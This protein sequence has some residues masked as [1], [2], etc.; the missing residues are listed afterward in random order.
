MLAVVALGFFSMCITAQAQMFSTPTNVSNN[1][2]FST[3]P[4]VA[5]DA[6]GNIYVV[7]EDDTNTNANILLGW[8]T[9]GGMKFFTKPLSNTKGFSSSPRICVDG[10]GAINVVWVDDTPG[11]PVVNFSR[12]TNG[13]TDFS[14]QQLSDKA[15][16]SA[17]PQIGVDGAGN[18]SVVWE[19]DSAPVG[20]LFR[21]STDGVTF[22]PAVNLA[23]NPVNPNLTGSLA[24]QMAVGVDGSINV[25]WEDDF[26]GQSDISFARSTDN[27]AT[28]S[29]TK[30]L[31]NNF[32]ASVGA[33]IAVDASGN[34]DVVWKDNTSGNNQILF[35]RSTDQGAHFL[36]A[37][38][39]SNGSYD[40]SNPQIQVGTNGSVYVTWQEI[41][42][43]SFN[44]SIFVA[45]SSDGGANFLLPLT[46]VSNDTGN[47][48]NPSIA[49][50]TAG[51]ID[52]SW[53]DTTP[54][55]ES[56]LFARSVDAGLT[57]PSQQNVSNDKGSSSNSHLL[58]DKNGNLYLVW[59]D[60]TP[61]VNQ[62][63]GWNQILFSRYSSPQITNQRPVAN[64]GPDQTVECGG[65]GGTL[66]MLNG[67]ASSDPDR[68]VLTYVWT[69]ELNN[70]VGTTVTPQFTEGMGA[71][72]FTLTVSDS[73]GL[74][75]TATTHVTIRDTVGPTLKVSL[76]S[77]AVW[78]HDRKFV[79]VSATVQTSDVCDASPRV[80]L[81]SIT[82][83]DRHGANDMRAMSG[84]PVAF[85]TDV[86]SFLLRWDEDRNRVFTITYK[87]TDAS[88]NTALASAQ[89]HVGRT[90]SHK[91][92]DKNKGKDNDEGK[93]DHDHEMVQT[94][95]EQN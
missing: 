10:K 82:S 55:K 52:L 46:D 88:G 70:L 73:A 25:V 43:P 14:T 41:V 16:F 36:N 22:S 92:R 32:G 3:T 67:S 40:S 72:T 31:S 34:I 37:N 54:G 84:G 83:N 12:S 59:S 39:L 9:N 53:L 69:D 15:A 65:P 61:P 47:A 48:T 77:K 18:I 66:I 76:S 68:D 91:D 85:G 29:A 86:R 58:A 13:G 60:D 20:I 62:T 38:N 75:S 80:Q 1:M 87:A 8:S 6:S 27:G 44:N 49:V 93:R 64:A 7:W 26:S 35:T 2:D 17:S 95:S 4:Q 90:R 94:P 74:K 81:V 63:S 89:V 33:Q 57:F 19:S 5:V 50:D 42:P 24:P 79:K 23:T 71:H 28:F 45:R 56:V 51:G 78:L 11:N 21:N 30:N